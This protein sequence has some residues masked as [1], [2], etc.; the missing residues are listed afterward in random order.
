MNQLQT[1][2]SWLIWA[3]RFGRKI[4]V[5]FCLILAAFVPLI[6][7]AF[8]SLHRLISEQH[9]LIAVHATELNLA[10][11]LRF[12]EESQFAS[13][14]VYILSGN[15]QILNKF[16]AAHLHFQNYMSKIAEI[17]KDPKSLAL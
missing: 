16:N 6:I 17:S 1:H 3:M 10:E 14:P 4:Y 7:L 5:G 9:S 12:E 13:M 11:L 15:I 8:F 2:P